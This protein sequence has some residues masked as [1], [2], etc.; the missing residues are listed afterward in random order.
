MRQGNKLKKIFWFYIKGEKKMKLSNQAM[1]SLMMALQR[2]LMEQTDITET[3]K[4]FVFVLDD[5]ELVVTNPPT[6]QLD[7]EDA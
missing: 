3:L 2:S 5:E 6:V 4:S 7:R 1:G